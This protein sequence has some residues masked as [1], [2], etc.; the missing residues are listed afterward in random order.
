MIAMRFHPLAPPPGM[1][2]A[3]CALLHDDVARKWTHCLAQLP[4][5]M[6]ARALAMRDPGRSLAFVA[7][8]LLEASAP[9]GTSH[10]LSHGRGV[11]VLATAR[12]RVGV[13]IE[14]VGQW[15]EPW[16]DALQAAEIAILCDLP[17]PGRSLS[18]AAVWS[19]K[20]AFCKWAGGGNLARQHDLAQAAFVSGS[21]G[22]WHRCHAGD[23]SVAVSIPVLMEARYALAVAVRRTQPDTL[24]PGE[25][26]KGPA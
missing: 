7:G 3:L 18:F 15:R 14:Q 13:D 17:E 9:R 20:E 19:A 24:S 21:A 11:T 4:R 1:P 12:E 16:P 22:A 10:S 26:E 2:V 6:Q 5:Q 25:S 8:R 23:C